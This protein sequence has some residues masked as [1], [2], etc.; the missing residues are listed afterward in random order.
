MDKITK[1]FDEGLGNVYERFMLNIFFDELLDFNP[2]NEVLEIPLFGMTGLTG[3]NSVHFADR[4]CRV[5]MLDPKKE[6]VDEAVEMWDLLPYKKDRYEIIH[7]N[8]LS[9]LPFEDCRFD[10][11]WDF[12]A[13]WHISET[14]KLLNE[15]ARVSSNLV[16]IVMPNKKQIGYLMRKY[17]LDKEF[18]NDVDEKWAD[19]E[20]IISELTVMGLRVMD[21]GV[22]DVPPWPDTCMPI[23]QLLEQL[24]LK[25]KED[26]NK[27]GKKWNW[28]IMSYY[29]GEDQTLKD[30]VERFSFLEK[31]TIPWQLKALWAHHRYVI[32]SKN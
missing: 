31:M 13:L 15:M 8:D 9:A 20:R 2:I 24:K 26:E 6:N 7:H 10:L 11:V 12:A 27:P 14:N 29:R 3:I 5:T 21:Q 16:F 22:L 1:H 17:I 25:K 19:I 28:D 32:F 4:G 30:K 23:G 18:F